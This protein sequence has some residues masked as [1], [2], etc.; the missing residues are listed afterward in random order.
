MIYEHEIP[1]QSHLYFGATAKLKR[2]IETVASEILLNS[3]YDEIVTPLLSYH[4][5]QSIDEKKLIKFSD[6]YNHTLSLR[7][8]ST[9]DVVRLIT[10]R[11]GRS[12]ENKKW[13]YIQPIFQYPSIQKYQVGAELIEN[14]NL[15]FSINDSI[16]IFQKLNLLPILQ[17]SNINIPK[18]I[19]K[20]LNISIELF[21]NANLEEILNIN[22]PWLNKL[23]YLREL[24]QIDDIIMDV[25]NSIKQELEQIKTL[26]KQIKYDNLVISPL[27]YAKMRYYDNLFFR[28][29]KQNSTLGMGGNYQYQNMNSSGFA[30]YIDEL[31]EELIK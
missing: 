29:F 14:S 26:A 9:L 19:A 16:K 12:T 10:K 30:L 22:L 7:F 24:S 15:F 13:F 21:K 28:F 25:P 8:D 31:I 23:V 3:G 2:Q 18:L 6:E 17:I 4:Q 5:H 11:L 27:Y 1:S 20:E